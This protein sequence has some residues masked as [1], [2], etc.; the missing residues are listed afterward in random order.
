[1]PHSVR[2]FAGRGR[3]GARR[4]TEWLSSVNVTARTALPA[5]TFIFDQSLSA[6]EL[7]K[8]PF[9]VTRTI[10]SLYVVSDQVAAFETPF[11][12]LGFIVVSDKAS[13]TGATA[14]PDPI[15]EE[16]S[17]GWFVYKSWA[18]EADTLRGQEVY[19]YDFDSRAQR[20]VED[21]SDIAVVMSNASAADGAR[22]ILKFRMLI[23]VA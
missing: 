8:R 10:G 5:G 4:M 19:R 12:A 15:T 14:V 21:G 7:A 20:K 18:A 16:A 3:T 1:M 13:A 17:D 22:Y 9:T 6:A 11:G 23:K 2:R